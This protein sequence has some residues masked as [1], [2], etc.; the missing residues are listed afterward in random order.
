M[1]LCQVLEHEESESKKVDVHNNV[2][3]SKY[4]NLFRVHRNVHMVLRAMHGKRAWQLT[5]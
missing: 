3:K 2:H 5:C 1:H 4:G